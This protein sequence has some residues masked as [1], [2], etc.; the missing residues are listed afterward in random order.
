MFKERLKEMAP[1]VLRLALALIFIYHGLEKVAPRANEWGA[2]WATNFWKKQAEPPAEVIAKLSEYT[3]GQKKM[4][5]YKG[6]QVVMARDITRTVYNL[7]K[8]SPPMG[9][10]THAVQLAVAWGELFGGAAMLLGVWTRLASVGLVV[11]QIGAIALVTG[12]RGFSFTEGGYE[13]NVALVAMCV[14]LI[15]TG[16]GPWAVDRI[17]YRSKPKV[18]VAAEKSVAAPV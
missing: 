6:E 11:I 2:S 12:F 16:S 4:E 18:A 9:L 10:G 14:A 5:S 15:L 3:P 17:K 7:D 1:L 13:Y 8:A